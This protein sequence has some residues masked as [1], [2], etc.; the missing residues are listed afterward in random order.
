MSIWRS[1]SYIS[2]SVVWCILVLELAFEF[3]LRPSNY[4]SLISADKA[5]APSTARHINRYH[6]FFEASALLLFI[7]TA[8]CVF[9]NTCRDSIY[10]SG[11][12]SAI[13]SVK[14]TEG[15]RAALGRLSNGLIFLRCFG[16]VRHWKQMWIAHTFEGNHDSE[17][18]KCSIQDAFGNISRQDTVFIRNLL[19][20]DSAKSRKGRLKR[21]LN[22]KKTDE[23]DELSPADAGITTE[24]QSN[25]ED[26]QL[27][28]AASVGTALMLINSHRA[29]ASL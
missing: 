17:G 11:I 7:P 22:R 5:Y 15:W 14:S 25:E 4:D 29:L 12:E 13:S 3:L 26:M 6:L 16:L 18:G 23:Q 28:N 24:K 2:F 21:L 20:V 9:R 19:L 10:L 8:Q 27:K 1:L